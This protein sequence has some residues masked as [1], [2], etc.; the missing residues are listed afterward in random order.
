MME[1]SVQDKALPL[2]IEVAHNVM[3][4]E[5]ALG[6]WARDRTHQAFGML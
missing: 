1:S 5:R 4:R 6:G 2:M 3:Q